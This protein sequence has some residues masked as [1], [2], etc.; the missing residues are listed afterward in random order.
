MQVGE[1]HHHGD[2]DQHPVAA[3]EP[4]ALP[5]LLEVR[6]RVGVLAR[7][8]TGRVRAGIAQASS[9]AETPND[10]ASTTSALAGPTTATRPPASAAPSI[11]AVRSTVELQPGDPL[12]RHAGGRREG[13]ASSRAFAASPG[14]RSAPATATRRGS[15]GTTAARPRAGTGSRRPRPASPSRSVIAT[16]RAP[17]RSM[18]GPPST[19]STHQRQHLGE[20]DEAG[21]LRAAGR[22]E[23]EERQR[24]HRDPGADERDA[25]GGRASRRAALP[26]AHEAST[27]ELAARA[28]ERLEHASCTAR[29]SRRR[30]QLLVLLELLDQR[31]RRRRSAARACSG[32]EPAAPSR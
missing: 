5:Q 8:A 7:A 11:D 9:S 21:L 16:R 15:P 25:L 31:P 4:P 22:G 2:A 30:R 20:R 23:H 10:A 29:R 24:D 17:T 19:L 28:R 27:A 1:R 14:P 13:R 32:V 26:G 6:R 18:I 12:H 3:Q